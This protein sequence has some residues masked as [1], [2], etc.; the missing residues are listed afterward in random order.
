MWWLCCVLHGQ[1]VLE[2]PLR[3]GALHIFTAR[4]IF[5]A[6]T[7]HTLGPRKHLPIM[8]TQRA[9][10]QN[11][12]SDFWLL[13]CSTDGIQVTH[14]DTFLAIDREYVFRVSSLMNKGVLSLFITSPGAWNKSAAQMSKAQRPST[15]ECHRQDERL[16]SSV[17]D[18]LSVQHTHTNK[19]TPITYLLP[20]S[21]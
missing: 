21:V 3:A 17:W 1:R 8:P 20:G 18:A 10:S 13:W 4:H 2:V 19:Y 7:C 15:L 14:N 5:Y 6:C 16:S 12:N 11:C 9:V